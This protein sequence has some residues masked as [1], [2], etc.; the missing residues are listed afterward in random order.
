MKVAAAGKI[1]VR[2]DRGKTFYAHKVSTNY[3]AALDKW[4]E[5]DEPEGAVKV[6]IIPPSFLSEETIAR[7]FPV[8]AQSTDSEGGGE[9][10]QNF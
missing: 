4:K 3:P 6:R 9:N 5:I 2:T 1:L 8:Y 7:Y 10:P